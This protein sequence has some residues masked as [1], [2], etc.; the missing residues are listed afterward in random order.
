MDNIWLLQPIK[1][2]LPIKWYGGSLPGLPDLCVGKLPAAFGLDGHAAWKV[3]YVETPEENIALRD[4][5]TRP[6]PLRGNFVDFASGPDVAVSKADA[7][8]DY[9][10]TVVAL[11]APEGSDVGWPWIT[12]CRL[13]SVTAAGP[14]SRELGRGVYSYDID[15]G[16]T[17]AMKRVE[18][19]QR[20]TLAAGCAPHVVYPDRS[21]SA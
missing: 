19:M 8:K 10:E 9:G 21:K 14:L 13:P 5:L 17:A 2:W 16:E 20:M 18:R 4:A 7:R 12:V 15:M 11:Y 3:W 6:V 1:E